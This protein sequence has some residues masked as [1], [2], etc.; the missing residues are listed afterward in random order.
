[1]TNHLSL[2]YAY[3]TPVP[4]RTEARNEPLHTPLVTCLHEVMHCPVGLQF[5]I[6]GV[7]VRF[8]YF[9]QVD[10][11]SVWPPIVAYVP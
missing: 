9:M 2:Q 1:M 6:S 4:T 3:L 10:A 5:D 8:I 7:V 11:E